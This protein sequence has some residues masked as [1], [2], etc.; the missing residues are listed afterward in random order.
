MSSIARYP[1]KFVAPAGAALD[2]AAIYLGES[3]TQTPR[4]Y[5][6]ETGAST[7]TLPQTVAAGASLTVYLLESVYRVSAK[8][9]DVEVAGGY[10][11]TK[12]IV[13]NG[14]NVISP[15]LLALAEATPSVS[16]FRSGF[17]SV[18]EP[19]AGMLFPFDPLLAAS[20]ITL[21]SGTAIGVD[22]IWPQS[23]EY[24]RMSTVLVDVAVAAGAATLGR[25]A[26]Y[27]VAANGDTTRLALSSDFDVDLTGT[28]LVSSSFTAAGN[29]TVG[30]RYRI[31]FLWVGS[32]TQLQLRASNATVPLTFINALDANKPYSGTNAGET[33]L[34]A[35]YVAADWAA[36]NATMPML[37][38]GLSA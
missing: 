34:A 27:E 31:A 11:S 22:F 9:N 12:R 3:G 19:A 7:V 32:G 26:L 25:T 23:T 21:T 29:L 35:S 37:I 15:D 13:A 28:G 18:I 1:V 8:V 30:T 10:N 17:M 24:S 20:T 2:A 38:G 14:L 6:A 36:N 16:E 5:A 4:I 33:D